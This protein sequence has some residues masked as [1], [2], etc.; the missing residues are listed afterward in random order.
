MATPTP[1]YTIIAL[2]L[3]CT[4]ILDEHLTDKENLCAIVTLFFVLC[5]YTGWKRICS[6]SLLSVDLANYTHNEITCK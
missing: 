6:F 3:A 4:M 2:D 1:L 5:I